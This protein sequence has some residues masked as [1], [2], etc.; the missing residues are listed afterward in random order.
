MHL[1]TANKYFTKCLDSSW[2]DKYIES[3]LKKEES[4]T[5]STSQRILKQRAQNWESNI[6]MCENTEVKKSWVNPHSRNRGLSDSDWSKENSSKNSLSE[7]LKF[8]LDDSMANLSEHK[9][10][11]RR[12]QCHGEGNNDAE[13]KWQKCSQPF[14]SK[15]HLPLCL[16]SGHFYWKQC[17]VKMQIQA[18]SGNSKAG[19]E[20]IKIPKDISKLPV[21]SMLINGNKSKKN[22]EKRVD[23]EASNDT[24]LTFSKDKYHIKACPKHPNEKLMYLCYSKNEVMWNDDVEPL[25]CV[26]WAFNLKQKDPTSR[27]EEI[28]IVLSNLLS[29]F[30]K[31]LESKIDKSTTVSASLAS[32]IT[33]SSDTL[34]STIISHYDTILTQLT[35]QKDRIIDEIKQHKSLLER[36]LPNVNEKS[37]KFLQ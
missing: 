2:L 20:N 19:E 14:D 26:Y 11:V 22:S 18:H 32:L 3:T 33:Q 35:L 12:N 30:K 4:M 7:R 17:I 6:Q 24:H 15:S 34:I 10:G 16:P 21:L 5:S 36:K 28:S 25:M 8:P 1:N 27:I 13:F 29:N 37:K 9:D 23:T 31:D